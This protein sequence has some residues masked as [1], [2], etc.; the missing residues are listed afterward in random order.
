MPEG[1]TPR[2]GA[3]ARGGE[4][5]LA[6]GPDRLVAVTVER[7]LAGPRPD[8]VYRRSLEAGPG[9]DGWP[10]LARALSELRA[11]IDGGEGPARR[12]HVALLPPLARTKALELP[13][14]GRGE[15][16]RLVARE[17]DRHF[18][19]VP[20]DPVADAV[21]VGSGGDGPAP[22]VAAC[23][24]RS[25]V[26]AV[27]GAVDAAGFGAGLVAPGVSA[28]A[29]GARSLDRGLRS[30]AAVLEL[31]PDGWRR[32]LR[33][34]DGRLRAVT[35]GAAVAGA[36]R[37]DGADD[38]PG[39]PDAVGP[40]ARRVVV[41]EEEDEDGGGGLPPEGLAAFGAL[42]QPEDG[43]QLL[44]DTA[45]ER[46]TRR[47]RTR[48]MGLGAAAVALLV[49]AGGVHLWGLEREIDAVEAARSALEGPVSRASTTREAA[50]RMS[51]LLASLERL[52]PDR[53]AWASVV[54]EIARALPASAHLEEL[55][56][57]DRGL[58][59]SGSAR[60]P[61]ALIGRLEDAPRLEGATL[62]NVS[63]SG[64]GDGPD[65]FRIVVELRGE[66]GP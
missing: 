11:E 39:A 25:T 5:G 53:P 19:R 3:R 34:E 32:E 58:V 49:V 7:G 23:A 45:R 26:E 64:D 30:G 24:E 48:A 27:L 13:A 40:D 17:L 43:L 59:L 12:A 66:A 57:T 8:R 9:E 36:D 62:E 56:V 46:W 54:A 60:S 14:A 42:V 16:R 33:L 20:D 50:D 15:L 44:P 61:S 1:L 10:E 2:L 31:A 51:G 6:V 4:V 47:L 38:S 63:R 41:G 28:A 52:R 37:D 29:E 35:A 22:S 21:V 55:S 18:V 65:A